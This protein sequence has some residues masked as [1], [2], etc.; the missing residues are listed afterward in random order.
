MS[1]LNSWLQTPTPEGLL[2]LGQR[3]KTA[4]PPKCLSLLSL[5]VFLLL[6]LLF[7]LPLLLFLVSF[8]P[9]YS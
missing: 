9:L 2:L 6:F 7:L 3:M 5:L 4:A 1:L 8:L